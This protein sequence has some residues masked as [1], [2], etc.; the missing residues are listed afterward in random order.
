MM[1]QRHKLPQE[2]VHAQGSHNV[3]SREGLNGRSITLIPPK[4]LFS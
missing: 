4:R 3:A 1:T 2:H